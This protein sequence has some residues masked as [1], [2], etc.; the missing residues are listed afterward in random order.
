MSSYHT[1]H[2]SLSKSQMMKLAHAHKSGISVTLQLSKNK[3]KPNGVPLQLT[4]SEYNLL[5]SN[6]K[7]H[8]I[9]ISASRVKQGGFLPALIAALPVVAS[10]LGGLAGVTSIASNI[11]SMVQGNGIISDLNIPIVSNLARKIGLGKKKQA[12]GIISDLGIPLLSP[13]AAKFGLGQNKRKMSGKGLFLN[14]A[15]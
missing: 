6:P 13:L 5:M 9:N 12:K 14:R 10:V 8:N 7:K 15:R 11:K 2:F 1:V 4:S 3:I